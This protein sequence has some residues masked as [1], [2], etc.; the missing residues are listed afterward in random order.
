ML[1][2]PIISLTD[3]CPTYCFNTLLEA[4]LQMPVIL[5]YYKF[6]KASIF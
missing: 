1:R 4:T 2:P 5:N 6:S 3:E